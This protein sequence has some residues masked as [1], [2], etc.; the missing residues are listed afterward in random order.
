M[1]TKFNTHQ[2]TQQ[3]VLVAL[4]RAAAT[5]RD[6]AVGVDY[7]VNSAVDAFR[8]GSLHGYRALNVA[9]AYAGW[10]WQV[11]IDTSVPPGQFRVELL[12]PESAVSVSRP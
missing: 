12:K 11:S 1:I 6:L 4:D 2:L 9:A 7:R 8:L 10:S 3:G 5:P